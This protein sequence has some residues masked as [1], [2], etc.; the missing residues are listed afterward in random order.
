MSKN[1][2]L[3]NNC[4][5]VAKRNEN[6]RKESEKST[7]QI[8][9]G[10]VIALYRLLDSEDHDD[11][12]EMINSV[13]AESLD[14]WSQVVESGGNIVDLCEEETGIKVIYNDNF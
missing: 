4:L 14:V 9:A 8:Y 11:K 7:P 3:I 10:M 12:V 6:F 2:R 5:A 1:N 13:L